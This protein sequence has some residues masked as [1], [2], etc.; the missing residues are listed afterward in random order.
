MFRGWLFVSLG[1]VLRIYIYIY[2][3]K[4]KECKNKFIRI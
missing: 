1:D 3:V 2:M 4:V